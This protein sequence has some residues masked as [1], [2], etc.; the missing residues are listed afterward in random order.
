[1]DL[2]WSLLWLARAKQGD[3]VGGSYCTGLNHDQYCGAMFLVSRAM[4]SHISYIYIS[5]ILK[6]IISGYKLQTRFTRFGSTQRK[7]EE[8]RETT[9]CFQGSSFRPK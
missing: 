1:M 3:E 5:H 8:R 9:G 4:A 6:V 7:Y 2:S